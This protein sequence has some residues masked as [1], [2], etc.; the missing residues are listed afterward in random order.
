MVKITAATTIGNQP[1]CVGPHHEGQVFDRYDDDQ[2][3]QDQRQNAEDVRLS[4]IDPVHGVKGLSERVYGTRTDVAEHD[5][6]GRKGQGRQIAAVR[7]LVASLRTHQGPRLPLP[8][9][10]GK[11]R[12]S[13]WPW[14]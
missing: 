12:E 2:G 1:P 8:A 14:V 6:Q 11:G 7:L 5:A 4:G 9:A 13:V 10:S 3:P